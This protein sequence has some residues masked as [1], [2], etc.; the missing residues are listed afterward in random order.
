MIMAWVHYVLPLEQGWKTFSVQ[1]SVASYQ[2]GMFF[3]AFISCSR[4]LPCQKKLSCETTL[5]ATQ[6]L[7]L[8]GMG[9]VGLVQVWGLH[10]LFLFQALLKSGRCMHFL[11]VQPEP[12]PS[13]EMS[14]EDKALSSCWLPGIWPLGWL[15]LLI[16]QDWRERELLKSTRPKE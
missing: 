2:I 12:C 1:C 14:Q 16:W 3:Y 10:A 6:L 5:K 7:G 13:I 11:I 8:L 15:G 9:G 4:K